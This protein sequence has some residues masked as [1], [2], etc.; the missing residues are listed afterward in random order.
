MAYP[1]SSIGVEENYKDLVERLGNSN[2]PI[3]AKPLIS[4]KL[5]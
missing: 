1:P 2:I 5:P 4:L 3:G